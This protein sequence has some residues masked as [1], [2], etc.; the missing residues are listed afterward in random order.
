MYF[1]TSWYRYRGDGLAP[2]GQT[3][4]SR[5]EQGRYLAD[6]ELVN[7][8]NTAL[9]VE[10]PLLVV[11]ESG[12]GKTMLAWS[13][14]SE[15]G[16]L[17]VLEFHTR[18]DHR[19]R[20]VL[21]VID[22]LRRFYDAQAGHGEAKDLANYIT[23]HALGAAIASDTPRVV[24]IDEIDKAP[25]D[26]PNDLLDEIDK[27]QF[28]L[29]DLRAEPFRA[30]HRPIVVIT[31]NNERQLPDPFLRRCVFHSIDFPDEKRLREIVA[32]RLGHLRLADRLVE[33]ATKRFLDFRDAALRLD[34]P[35][36]T[37]ELLPWVRMLAR[38]GI[39]VAQLDA[40]ALRDLPFLGALVKNKGDLDRI[41]T[42]A[43]A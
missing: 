26:F 41:R 33:V 3:Y 13:I 35:P 22:N 2:E 7:A 21:F 24:L 15:L 30:T 31:S 25:R 39:D 43:A 36:A 20:D 12:T 11:G 16:L 4:D 32:E 19:A 5:G 42:S 37:G 6:P 29:P 34:K 27:M 38:S 9:T 17:P 10:Q 1:D 40:V 14:A 28:T 23:L 8:V 18:S